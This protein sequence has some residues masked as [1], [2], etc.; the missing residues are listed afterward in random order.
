MNK[1]I[2]I[3][4][5]AVALT[6][7]SCN[8]NEL[9]KF[10]DNDAFLAFTSTSLLIDENSTDS[11]VLE[12]LCTSLSGIESQV[13]I[14]IPNDT[15]ANAAVLDE[16][17]TYYTTSNSN[18]LS[19]NKRVTS[20]KIVIKPIDNDIFTGDKHFAFVLGTP[21]NNCNLGANTECTITIGDDEHPL[22]FI[23]GELTARGESYFN[24]NEEWTVTF[25]KDPDGDLSKVWIKNLVN[26][27]SSA[28]SPVYGL[29]NE[30]KN[31]LSIP[32]GQTI[33]FS[34]AYSSVTLEGF[35]GPDGDE[36]IQEGDN[37]FADIAP[38][39]TITI[40]DWFGSNI[41]HGNSWYN[42]YLSGVTL[43]KK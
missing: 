35:R 34:S 37:I 29:V 26:K 25:S 18:T 40:R 27:G 31:L 1:R 17:F 8:L 21:T 43:S 7:G 30:E 9:P 5:A 10:D 4:V 42:I 2:L 20:H 24:G 19:F 16:D 15:T 28:S 33:A 22:A 14:S 13:T 38:D 23:L 41:E 32:V 12:V 3:G 36:D 6:L 11:L 39:G